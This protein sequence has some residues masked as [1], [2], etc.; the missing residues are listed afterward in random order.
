MCRICERSCVQ[1]VTLFEM[2]SIRCI[3]DDNKCPIHNIKYSGLVE[4]HH[5]HTRFEEHFII[6]C[7]WMCI[8]YLVSSKF[9][10]YLCFYDGPRT[11]HGG[12][13]FVFWNFAEL[14]A[15]L[16]PLPNR[17][18]VFGWRRN[19]RLHQL[20]VLFQSTLHEERNN[21]RNNH[22]TQLLV[23]SIAIETRIWKIVR[24]CEISHPIISGFNF[25]QSMFPR[26]C[27]HFGVLQC[28]WVG[29]FRSLWKWKE[30]G[31]CGVDIYFEANIF[32]SFLFDIF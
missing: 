32:Y 29:L 19:H 27:N 26:A 12:H 10:L 24:H 16:E 31:F 23:F 21:A 28:R 25:I 2:L 11:C 22:G 13:G 8:A 5:M 6:W 4:I 15:T 20:H 1:I 7:E 30:D 17:R 18:L 3:L 14:L 9:W